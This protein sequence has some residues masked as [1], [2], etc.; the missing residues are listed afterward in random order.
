[1]R[2][3]R[4]SSIEK[5]SCSNGSRTREGGEGELPSCRRSVS[6]D[7]AF[8]EGREGSE[9]AVGDDIFFAIEPDLYGFPFSLGTFDLCVTRQ[10][11]FDVRNLV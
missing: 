5:T 10:F 1:M 2:V 6:W 11:L 9:R 3:S 8:W 7:L 4:S